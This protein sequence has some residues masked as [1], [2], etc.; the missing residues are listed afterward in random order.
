MLRYYIII[1]IQF[2]STLWHY[3]RG[4]NS[5]LWCHNQ[6]VPTPSYHIIINIFN[7][8]Y[9]ITIKV[10]N[11]TLWHNPVQRWNAVHERAGQ[12][13]STSFDANA[14]S[15][16]NGAKQNRRGR[17]PAIKTQKCFARPERSV[18][19]RES[20]RYTTS[21]SAHSKRI[22]LRT[23]AVKFPS[24]KHIRFWSSLIRTSD[25][26]RRTPEWNSGSI[27]KIRKLLV[28]QVDLIKHVSLEVETICVRESETLFF[29]LWKTFYNR[30]SPRRLTL[31]GAVPY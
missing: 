25:T 20:Q 10:F 12:R 26:P 18:L 5:M 9:D 23:K 31:K 16:S 19:P 30:H 15:H 1:K 6:G 11:F 2:R 8:P 4:F 3:N 14:R 27:I 21:G 17:L 24:R 7:S 28:W 13:N 29:A 22:L